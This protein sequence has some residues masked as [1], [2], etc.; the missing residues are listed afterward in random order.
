[1]KLLFPIFATVALVISQGWSKLQNNAVDSVIPPVAE[2]Q[3]LSD[4]AQ[5]VMNTPTVPVVSVPFTAPNAVVEVALPVNVQPVSTYAY[6][7]PAGCAATT[8][9]ILHLNRCWRM[10]SL[11][12]EIAIGLRSAASYIFGTVRWTRTWM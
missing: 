3:M 10:C 8:P 4:A 11:H 12:L 6:G 9:L 7:N 1:M 5:A 2:T